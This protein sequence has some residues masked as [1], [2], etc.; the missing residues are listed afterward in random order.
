MLAFLL[1]LTLPGQTVNLNHKINEGPQG[2]RITSVTVDYNEERSSKVTIAGR[3]RGF[4]PG[5]VRFDVVI[6]DGIKE[7]GT[8]WG[9]I[10][11]TPRQNFSK[12]F[13]MRFDKKPDRGRAE[14]S[15]GEFQPR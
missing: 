5:K 15:F 9:Y 6:K 3:Y 14:F 11:M 12:T 13:Y 7:V 2:I 4:E 8:Q 10:N 1:L